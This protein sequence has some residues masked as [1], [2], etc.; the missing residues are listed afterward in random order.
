MGEKVVK[1]LKSLRFW[2]FMPKG[3]RVLAQS[4]STAPPTSKIFE[5]MIYVCLF[6]WYLM[7]KI[8][9]NI[10]QFGMLIFN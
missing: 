7:M 5:M 9:V 1:G 2:R 10:F 4:K 8:L 6:N 3:E